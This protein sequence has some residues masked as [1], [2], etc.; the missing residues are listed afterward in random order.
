MAA[1]E[2]AGSISSYRRAV[3]APYSPGRAHRRRRFAKINKI[4]PTNLKIRE[5]KQRE[6]H[7]PLRPRARLTLKDILRTA[8]PAPHW[9]APQLRGP[10]RGA[11]RRLPPDGSCSHRSRS[12]LLNRGV[13]IPLIPCPPPQQGQHHPA[14]GSELETG[15]APRNQQWNGLSL[16][17]SIPP[18]SCCCPKGTS[19]TFLSLPFTSRGK[20]NKQT[21]NNQ[22]PALYAQHPAHDGEHPIILHTPPPLPLVWMT[23]PLGSQWILIGLILILCQ[24]MS[25]SAWL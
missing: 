13:Q 3:G 6:T 23:L 7:P 21:N 24:H 18:P 12:Q 8:G 2:R 15:P 9:S 1:A 5:G 17:H 14:A 19:C 16:Q 25:Y 11:A 10:G 20:T 4:K 22:K